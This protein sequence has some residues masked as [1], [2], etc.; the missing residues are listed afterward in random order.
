[1]NV[2][3]SVIVVLA[4]LLVSAAEARAACSISTTGVNFGTYNVFSPAPVDS[5]GS[6]TFKCA[7][8]D[9]NI[10]VALS[11]GNSGTFATRTMRKGAETLPYNL[12]RDAAR[13]TVW[14]DGT[15]GT[16]LYT[17]TWP[18]GQTIVLTIYGR[19]FAG[20]DVSPGSYTD[21]VTAVINF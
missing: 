3:W 10:S 2:R 15:A 5:T 4:M 7:F 20:A 17:N 9:F 1:V 12:F 19:I 6:I 21:T 8:F 11:P 14:G 16:G 13:T 18:V